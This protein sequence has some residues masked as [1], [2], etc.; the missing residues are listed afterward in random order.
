M[1]IIVRK[2]T[3]EDINPIYQLAKKLADIPN[4]LA[5]QSSEINLSDI[6]N[7]V[8]NSLNNGKIYV[9]HKEDDKNNLIGNIYC[10]KYAPNSLKHCLANLTIGVLK[11]YQNYGIG[12]NLFSTL[13]QD[14]ASN[15]KEIAR[16][17]LEV[18]E[19]N[20]KAITLYQSLGFEIEAIMKNRILDSE[21]NLGSD[22][23][24]AW[25]NPNF[26]QSK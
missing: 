26:Q 5:R 3:I 10:Y 14:V 4:G 1:N 16:I 22:I 17:Q 9:A 18:R 13:L 12:R 15:N 20:S 24:M 6:T 23:L 8:N 21:G 11:E 25:F 7:I 2:A 19:S